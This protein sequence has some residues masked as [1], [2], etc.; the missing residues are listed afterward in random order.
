M[1]NL[2][3][4]KSNNND[5]SFVV[6][7]WFAE[8]GEQVTAQQL[9][10]T[11][12]TSKAT[13]ELY[14]ENHGILHRVKLA[15]ERCEFGVTIGYI[16]ENEAERQHF[17]TARQQDQ[18]PERED[19]TITRVAQEMMQ[20]HGI[21]VAEVRQL[22]KKL[23][24]KSD[25]EALL[26]QH[27][28]GHTQTLT[29]SHRQATIAE[30][31]SRSH[32]V[33]PRA[34]LA[35]R[36]YCD[37]ALHQLKELSSQADSL[38]GLTELLVKIIAGLHPQFPFFFGTLVNKTEFVPAAA[39]HIGVTLDVGKGLF[40]PVVRDAM[41]LT[42]P[43]IAD[44]LMDFRIKAF[45]NSFKLEELSDGALTISLNTEPDIVFVLPII[46]PEQ[47]CMLTLNAVQEELFLQADQTVAIRSYVILGLAYDHRV[48]NG[49]EAV[50]FV[51]AIKSQVESAEQVITG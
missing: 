49:F 24:K 26:R 2:V 11:V 40:I 29:L 21:S 38:I 12:E 22:G 27:T 36:V 9:V 33:I 6:A 50:Q 14:S 46:L 8:N 51:K 44:I 17:L 23:V 41:T 15:G 25:I 47:T 37:Q 18:E 10:A 30:T 34:F 35:M 5:D 16:F 4:T 19:F 39:P 42:L 31:V 48:I 20:Q 45:R 28:A 1:H 7:E 13:I 3:V 32:A 43:E